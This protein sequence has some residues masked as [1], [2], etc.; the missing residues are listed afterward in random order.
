MTATRLQRSARAGI[1]LNAIDTD[2]PCTSCGYNLKGLTP[3][4]PCPECG[5][6][7]R[8]RSGSNEIAAPLLDAPRS[9]VTAIGYGCLGLATIK[10]AQ[11]LVTITLAWGGASVMW[12]H[13]ISLCFGIAWASFAWLATLPRPG[14]SQSTPGAFAEGAIRWAARLSA[15]LIPAASLA[16]LA[17]TVVAK[18]GLPNTQLEVAG[19]WIHIGGQVSPIFLALAVA[20]L[21]LSG[22][23]EG[24]AWRTRAAAAAMVVSFVVSIFAWWLASKG[25]IGV[26]AGIFIVIA[27]AIMLGA[28]TL[29]MI[30]LVQ[31]GM[32]ML[33]AV[34]YADESADRERRRLER[35]ARE[36]ERFKVPA[37]SPIG[38]YTG[39]LPRKNKRPTDPA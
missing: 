31:V 32:M 13:A 19:A 33:W 37:S 24:I 21:A 2:R 23:D 15:L 8:P 11:I 4:G 36:R 6:V 28:W 20:N 29:L 9:L 17:A 27:A 10:A 5:T 34:K 1:G 26:G 22:A 38:P 25:A 7:I 35:E 12:I 16:F 18:R 39:A 30:G 14:A 3:G